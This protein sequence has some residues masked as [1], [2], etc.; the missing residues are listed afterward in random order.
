MPGMIPGVTTFTGRQAEMVWQDVLAPSEPGLDAD[1]EQ[2]V[3][4]ALQA[5]AGAE[6][7]LTALIARYQP[8]VLRYLMRLT[9][10]PELARTLA[11]RIFIRMERRL[12]GPHGAQLLR[13]WLLR[14]C[15]E[16][17]LDALRH[18][19][20][21]APPRLGAP[22]GPRGLLTERA[23]STDATGRLKNGLGKIAKATQS[24]TRQVR[25]LI[26]TIR[27]EATGQATGEAPASAPHGPSGARQPSLLANASEIADPLDDELDALD[28]REAFRHRLIRAVLAEITYGDAQCLALHLVAGLNQAEVAHALGLTAS[29]TR[30]RIVQGLQTFSA[31]YATALATMGVPAELGYQRPATQQLDDDEGEETSQI[32]AITP[33]LAAAYSPLTDMETLRRLDTQRV[34]DSIEQEPTLGRLWPPAAPEPA[35]ASPAAPTEAAPTSADTPTEATPA[36]VNTPYAP[37]APYDAYDAYDAY[38]ISAIFANADSESV[39]TVPPADMITAADADSTQTAVPSAETDAADETDAFQVVDWESADLAA[40]AEQ[41]APLASYTVNAAQTDAEAPGEVGAV[42]LATV[43]LT[44]TSEGD[45]P[46]APYAGA[47]SIPLSLQMIATP[48]PFDAPPAPTAEP[49]VTP[50]VTPEATP[51]EPP[52]AAPAVATPA[53]ASAGPPPQAAA[54]LNDEED[55]ATTQ[56][57][58]RRIAARL[59]S[60]A[61]IAETPRASVGADA[62]T[63][64]AAT[65][66]AVYHTAAEPVEYLTEAPAPV[67]DEQAVAERLARM[68]RSGMVSPLARDAI[69][70]PVVDALPVS[71]ITIPLTPPKVIPQP[72][73][74]RRPTGQPL[75]FERAS[76]EAFPWIVPT[77]HEPA[78]K[79]RGRAT[80]APKDTPRERQDDTHDTTSTTLASAAPLMDGPEQRNDTEQR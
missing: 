35:T 39:A 24:T 77:P 16:A 33:P 79:R 52:A 72:G 54:S 23:D 74:T 57:S 70:G 32:S 40:F 64:D 80:S 21:K 9:G 62:A 76:A 71:P 30:R 14:A 20:R 46:P 38:D 27:A 19:Q 13:L 55:G 65:P 58:L 75:T 67:E 8:P 10:N 61:A 2:E 73:A 17:G 43:D 6:W 59:Q 36:S 1:Q 3:R 69:V 26:W 22:A 5:R 15:T 31:R 12:H 42:A 63:P 60:A 50:E 7:A 66:D 34:I 4:L 68:Q 37:P 56:P 49:E 18:P 51:D 25:Q 45:A 28:P 48:M 44:A 53:Q 29:A 47:A 78:D 41:L 11:E